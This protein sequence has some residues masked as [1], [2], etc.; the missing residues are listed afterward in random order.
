M[1]YSWKWELRHQSG[2]TH[3]RVDIAEL[4]ERPSFRVAKEMGN[5]F[6]IGSDLALRLGPIV[7][8]SIWIEAT[9]EVVDPSNIILGKLLKNRTLG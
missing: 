6:N 7:E 2:N 4:R 9:V 1:E 8:L 5:S 3:L